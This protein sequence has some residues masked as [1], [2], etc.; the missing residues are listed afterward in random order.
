[1]IHKKQLLQRYFVFK[2]VIKAL[3]TANITEFDQKNKL[4]H[5]ESK[6]DLTSADRVK[7]NG[8]F[9]ETIG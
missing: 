6:T 1:M 7:T 2:D 5:F 3:L 4:K 8:C 9:E